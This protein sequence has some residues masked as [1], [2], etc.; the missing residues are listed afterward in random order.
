MPNDRDLFE[1]LAA[2]FSYPEADKI[3]HLEKLQEMLATPEQRRQ[4]APFVAFVREST[5]TDLEELF[6]RSFDLNP[7][8]CLEIGWHLY[9]EDYERGRFLVSMRQSLR[10]AGIP[11]SVELPDHLSH[12]LRLLATMPEE[13]AAPFAQRFL[14]P[15]LDKVARN[16]AEHNPYRGLLELLR[17]ELQNRYGPAVDDHLRV[18]ARNVAQTK[19]DVLNCSC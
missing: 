12:C 1:H 10:E 15:A 3:A 8:C 17:S 11:E 4:I 19:L 9:G 5:L 14:Q 18:R 2:L 13:D 16:L 7:A 6:T